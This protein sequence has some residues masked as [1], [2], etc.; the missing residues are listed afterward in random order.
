M[1][2]EEKDDEGLLAEVSSDGRVLGGR[3]YCSS[4]ALTLASGLEGALEFSD[5]LDWTL[6][7]FG[8]NDLA[9][10]KH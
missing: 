3:S 6:P 1:I 9:E 8:D 4:R 10:A 2:L 5:P 7:D